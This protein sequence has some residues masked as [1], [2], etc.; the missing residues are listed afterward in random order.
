[1]VIN[2]QLNDLIIFTFV[3]DQHVQ[4]QQLAWH[5][6]VEIHHLLIDEQNIL[7]VGV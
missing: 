7:N 3:D 4:T 6:H 2:T 1:M 5:Q